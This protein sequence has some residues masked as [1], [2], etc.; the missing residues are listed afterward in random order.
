VDKE[1]DAVLDKERNAP[2]I[3]ERKKIIKTETLPTIARKAPALALFTS[4][5]IH[6]YDKKLDGL[7][8]Y[9]NGMQDMT[10]ATLA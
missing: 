8:I 9:P 2:S 3:E 10:K 5:F 7:Y 6:A 4:V 1:I